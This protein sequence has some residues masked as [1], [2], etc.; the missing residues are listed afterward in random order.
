MLIDSDLLS[1]IAS[2][3]HDHPAPRDPN[4]FDAYISRYAAMSRKLPSVL[5]PVNAGDFKLRGTGKSIRAR[6]HWPNGAVQPLLMVWFVGGGWC[7]GTLDTHDGLC[8]QLAHDL[9]V[10][11]AEIELAPAAGRPPLQTCEEALLALQTLADGRA[12]LGVNTERLLAGGDGSGAHH[13]LQASWRMARATPGAVDAVL[14]LYPL[15]KPDFNTASYVRCATSPT[16]SRHD[17]VRAWGALLGN[18]WDLWDE[19]AVLMHG[20]APVQ[21]PPLTVLLAAE[22]DGAHDDAIHLHDWLKSIGARCEFFGA[23]RM[24]HDFARMQ[25]ASPGA[26]KLLLDALAAFSQLARLAPAA[27][28][29]PASATA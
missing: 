18:R 3:E 16:F 1:F 12:K 17:A 13:A 5:V 7:A 4:D 21:N 23:P 26:R 19:R 22:Q 25:H 2:Q 9:G 8:R 29:A 15:A 27:V 6:L 11:V 20:N 10:A 28:S 14:G 24:P